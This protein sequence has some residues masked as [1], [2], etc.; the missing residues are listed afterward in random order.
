MD[1]YH[2]L[3]EGQRTSI[4]SQEATVNLSKNTYVM[5]VADQLK[6][7]P[8]T[9]TLAVTRE[10]KNHTMGFHLAHEECQSLMDNLPQIK[11]AVVTVGEKENGEKML[12][13]LNN[14][15]A[16]EVCKYLDRV[17]CGIFT[18]SKD[19]RINRFGGINFGMME[20]SNLV[21]YLTKTFPPNTGAEDTPRPPKRARSEEGKWGTTTSVGVKHYWWKWVKEDEVLT[22]TSTWQSSD[23]ACLTSALGN[24]PDSPQAEVRMESKH[25]YIMCDDQFVQDLFLFL[26]EQKIH[27]LRSNDCEGCEMDCPGQRDHMSGCLMEWD[28]AVNTYMVKANESITGV[29]MLYLYHQ[30]MKFAGKSCQAASKEL[31]QFANFKAPQDLEVKL[32]QLN[33]N[34]HDLL[35]TCYTI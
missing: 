17:Y 35:T 25:V 28:E 3:R 30:V 11:T 13:P 12:I 33:I 26:M 8:P 20:W 23:E 14:Y 10:K 16:V 32:K 15:W 18:M 5:W 24:K 22:E 2:F 19:Q 27:E 29:Q 1:Y 9:S 21:D 34:Y 4:M 6:G 31:E 7:G